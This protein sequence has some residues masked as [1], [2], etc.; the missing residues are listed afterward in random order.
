MHLIA[1][2]AEF[3]LAGQPRTG[4]PILLWEDMRSCEPANE[5]LR[6]YL[7]RGA[8]GSS[9]SWEPTGRAIYDYFGFLEAHDLSWD[10]VDR[11]ER[12]TLV[13]AYR[14][15]SFETAGLA[16]NTIRQR[17]LYVCEFYAFAKRQGWVQSLPYEYE[18]RQVMRSG[19]FLSHVDGSGGRQ[20]VRSVMPRKHQALKKFLSKQ[21][22]KS[23]LAAAENPH[24]HIIIRLAVQSGLRREELA[25][26]PLA[27]VV[28]PDK[29]H[30]PERNIRVTLDPA[31]GTGMST[32]GSKPRVI[33]VSRRLM[34]ELHHYAIHWRG[35]RASLNQSAQKALFLNQYGEPWA[36]DGKGIEAMVRK[37]GAKVGVKAHPHMLRHTYATHTLAALQRNR[38]DTHI[39]PLV[40]LQKQLGHASITTTMDYLHLVNEL[41]D[42]AV[43]AYDDELND[44]AEAQT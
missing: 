29:A 20:A 18:G 14:D 11:G 2:T 30:G 15:Y 9:N 13:A 37:I 23:L 44:W 24:H 16:R 34:K 5:F 36:A 42:D 4:F 7:L 35:E 3:K 38:G 41:A 12:K 26:F 39:E 40:F 27:Y 6:Y 33:Y 8:I 32:K 25:T 43:L 22:T 1:A 19:G 17:L 21:Q 31:D 28:D 10:D